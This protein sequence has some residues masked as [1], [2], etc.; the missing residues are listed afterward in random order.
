MR[1]D[2]PA[3]NLFLLLARAFQP[4][5]EFNEDEPRL[6]REALATCGPDLAAVGLDLA[7]QWVDALHVD[8]A[9]LLRDY[10][11]LFLG[12]FEIKAAPYASF[13]LDPEQRL[14]G[15]VSQEVACRYAEAGLAPAEGPCDA[16]DHIVSECEFLY[17][18]AHQYLTIE[19]E[20][21][22]QRFDDFLQTHFAQWLPGLADAM[23]ATEDLHPFYRALARFCQRL[24]SP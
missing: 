15:A 2:A 1:L 7:A 16:P 21:W 3:A 14:M 22:H 4:P 24:V 18:L 10:A 19:D 17:F 5:S 12:P 23:L 13:Y 11:R 9:P 6:L 8:P 20:I